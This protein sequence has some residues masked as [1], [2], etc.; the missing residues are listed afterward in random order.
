MWYLPGPGI[1]PVSPALAGRFFTTELPGKPCWWFSCPKPLAS[2]SSLLCLLLATHIQWSHHPPP[3]STR[4]RSPSDMAL[5]LRTPTLTGGARPSPSGS[6]STTTPG[7]PCPAPS[8]SLWTAC[9]SCTTRRRGSCATLS[10]TPLVLWGVRGG[11]SDW[12][13]CVCVCVCL[14]A[15]PFLCF[16]RVVLH[17]LFSVRRKSC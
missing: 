15:W 9:L 17:L 7:P 14:P 16:W 4:W 12:E 8:S 10:A 3:G 11:G 6:A 1:E 5:P 2:S 13:L